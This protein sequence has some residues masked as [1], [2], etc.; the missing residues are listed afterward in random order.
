METSM[1]LCLY[2]FLYHSEK[3]ICKIESENLLKYEFKS[4]SFNSR[5]VTLNVELMCVNKKHL[6]LHKYLEVRHAVDKKCTH[7]KM[8]QSNRH[9]RWILELKKSFAEQT[10]VQSWVLVYCYWLNLML[11]RIV[12]IKALM[13]VERCKRCPSKHDFFYLHKEGRK[14][15][16]REWFFIRF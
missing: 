14:C 10:N 2:L 1:K 13:N 11:H 9:I 12:A 6:K 7:V 15:I 16:S 5:N 4:P 3:Q 8:W